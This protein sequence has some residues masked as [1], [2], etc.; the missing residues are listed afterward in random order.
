MQFFDVQAKKWKPLPS[1]AQLSEETSCF[2]ALHVGNYM[3][4]AAKREDGFVN[5]R[6]HT[7]KNTWETL[8]SFAGLAKQISCL[9]SVDDHIYA[10]FQSGSPYRFH[11]STNQWQCVAKLSAQCNLPQSSFCNKAAAVFRS[12]IYVLH[13][14]G[15]ECEFNRTFKH[16][17]GFSPTWKPRVADLF[18]FDP[19]KNEWEQKASTSTSHF[20]SS[21][22]VVNDKLYVAGGNCS[23]G[24]YNAEP[25][26]GAGSVEVYDEKNNTWSVVDQP[27]IPPNNLGAI[28][29][30]G[31]VYFIINSFPV[32]SGI[33]IP[34]GEVYS[35]SLDEWE[36]LGRVHQNA[37]FCL[38]PVKTES[39]TSE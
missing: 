38:V 3:Y 4:V 36:D 6:Y 10:M 12:L 35:V 30:E 29:V 25:C 31:S 8:P 11:I 21:L 18:C 22:L 39:L 34:P 33:R 15:D 26:G 5:Y 9:C 2:C 17:H 14:R 16:I 1:K 32:D 37:I 7:V 20:G 24:K 23:I 13:G 19:K 27:H 28:E